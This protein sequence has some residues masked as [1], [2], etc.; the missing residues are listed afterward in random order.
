ME[1]RKV[2]L[3]VVGAMKAGTTSFVDT[4]SEHSDI[5]ISP[6]KEPNYFTEHLPYNLYQPSRFFDLNKYFEKEF[7]EPLH[8]TKIGS[9]DQYKRLFSLAHNEKYLCD[10]STSYL[11]SPETA[12]KIFDYNPKAKIIVILREPLDRAF[13][14]YRMDVAMSRTKNSFE[15]ILVEEIA[16][17]KVGTLPWNSYLG[18]SF[19]EK[20]LIEYNQYFKD[21]FILDFKKLKSENSKEW[22]RLSRFLEIPDFKESK[23]A[24]KNKTRTLR[25]QNLFYILKRIG[26]KDYFSRIFSSRIKRN[27]FNL[28]ST[29]TA[30]EMKLSGELEIEINRIFQIESP[31]W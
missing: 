10:S 18:M 20:A 27:L 29:E 2:N 16:Q 28:L 6:I 23:L 31:K 19:Y 1:E 12:K 26:L 30:I 3:F 24:Q 14:H 8:I 15:D 22:T 25:F 7:P 9:M 17:Y 5:F 21:V 13:S 11:H 4:I